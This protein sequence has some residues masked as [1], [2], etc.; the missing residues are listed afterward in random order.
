VFLR[1]DQHRRP[2]QIAGAAITAM[3][4]GAFV[5]IT[6]RDIH[7]WLPADYSSHGRSIDL[8]FL[9][10]FWLTL[11]VLILVE[12]LLIWFVIAYR[13]RPDKTKARFIHGNTRLEMLWTLIPAAIF[14]AIAMWSRQVWDNYR[15]SPLA[16]DPRRVPIL[17]IG[18]QFKWNVIYPGP[19]GK[20]GRYL[21]YPKVTDLHWPTVPFGTA[22]QFPPV[23]GPAYLP[24]SE[25]KKYLEDYVA[26][27]NPLGKDFDDPDGQDD[28]WQ[29][30]LA[31][32]L[33][34]PKGRPVEIHLASKDVIHDFY[35]PNFRVKLDAV[36][37]SMGRLYFEATQ[38][39]A[40]LEQ[41]SR[42]QYSVNELDAGLRQKKSY[43]VVIG[44]ETQG[45]S[46]KVDRRHHIHYWRYA[47]KNGETIIRDGASVTADAIAALK[48]AGI[49]ELSAYQPQYF[50]L[51]CEQLCGAEH[52]TMQDRVIVLEDDE[53][54]KKYE[55][56]AV[57]S[58]A[59]SNALAKR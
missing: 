42:R 41:A 21:V 1:S 22:I 18:E 15:Y 49:T 12:V 56:P 53:F 40:E 51:V 38:S 26:R 27:I 52:Y 16:D 14:L 47:D 3:A 24:E 33:E 4:V 43:V 9:F 20:L 37:G 36:P 23:P 48:A 25:A 28:I 44:P 5:W 45:A 17:V 7:R 8:I 55:S 31:R 2:L 35:L 30:A 50:E 32:P 59:V 19:D 46:E 10:I 39:S 29:G 6:A 13:R 58:V 54:R 34:V 57:V 11:A